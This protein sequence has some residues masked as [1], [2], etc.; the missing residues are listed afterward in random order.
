MGT[1]IYYF[2]GTGNSLQIARQ[3]QKQLKDSKIESM[4]KEPPVQSVGGPEE[5]IGFVFPVYYWGP[6][7][8]VKRFTEKLDISKGT[9][10]FAVINYGRFK[11]DTLSLLD[12]V[13]KEKGAE[14]SYGAGI[15]LPGNYIVNYDSKSPEEINKITEEATIQ[16]K[17]I[18]KDIEKK[19]VRPIKRFLT[20]ISRWGNGLIYKNIENFDEKFIVT[21][22]CT[23][24][25]LCRDICPVQNIKL[26]N[27][28][29]TWF[30]HCERCMACIQWCPVEAIQYGQKTVER[31]RYHNPHV[32]AEDIV[33][34]NN[35][36]KSV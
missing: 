21:E 36:D 27:Q 31:R 20:G 22:N 30:H 10:C 14:L 4:A 34:G 9:Y 17:K 23:S 8:I 5:I 29:P 11:I 25:G 19:E 16:I 3:L 24:C 13:L 28:K 35:P 15:R 12:D 26:V 1:T 7:R 6:P 2:T 32:T 33:E 18:A